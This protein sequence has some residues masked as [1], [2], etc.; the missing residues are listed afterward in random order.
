MRILR[1][2][3]ILTVLALAALAAAAAWQ[4]TTFESAR[5]AGDVHVIYGLDGPAMASGN[6]AVLRTAAG[7]V[8]VDSMTFPFHGR[9]IRTRAEEL[10]AGPVQVVIN[11][12][13]HQDHT[14]GNPGFADGTR[15]VATTRTREHLL[16]RDAASWEGEAAAFLPTETFAHGHDLEIGGKTIRSLHLG[17]GHTDGDLVVLFEADR[18]LAAGDL[19]WNRHYPNID[20]EAGGSIPAWDATLDE[21]LKLDFDHVIPGHG[22]VMT[23]DEVVAFQ[24]FIRQLWEVSRDAVAA[25]TSLEAAVASPALTAD[26]GFGTIAI[27]FVIGLDRAFVLRRGYEEAS[28]AGRGG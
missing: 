13:Y 8:V 24:G 21:I 18:V 20:L 28:R 9:W 26:A 5:V 10:G 2:F 4:I 14:H 12:H 11:T 17:R 16:A 7:A 23:R 3:A 25:G 19:V 22:P 27:P 15:V 6:V 1:T